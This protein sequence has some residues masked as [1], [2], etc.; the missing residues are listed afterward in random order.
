MTTRFPVPQGWRHPRSQPKFV[1]ILVLFFGTFAAFWIYCGVRAAV[2]GRLV[3]TLFYFPS[4]FGFTAV[5]FLSLLVIA[6]RHRDRP[7]PSSSIQN[8]RAVRFRPAPAFRFG[9]LGTLASGTVGCAAF[10]IGLW[11]GVLSFP[12]S[13]GQKSIFP[14]FFTAFGLF[15]LCLLTLFMI[16]RFRFPR[17]EC[18]PE[19]LI[20]QGFRAQDQPRGNAQPTSKLSPGE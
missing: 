6:Q 15:A 19:E 12:L 4:A 13:S 16:D 5:C 9:Y 20:V 10:S 1:G 14:C 11:S 18:T 17:V 7:H 3:Y 8:T 2:E